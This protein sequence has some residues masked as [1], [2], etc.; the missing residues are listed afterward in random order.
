[1]ILRSV[2]ILCSVNGL[3][4]LSFTDHRSLQTVEDSTD[5][6][7]LRSVRIL[8]SVDGLKKFL[9]YRAQKS[10]DRRY[11]LQTVGFYGL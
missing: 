6:R 10:T 11:F 2:G 4:E 7:V 9:F 3:K 1:M 8:W 5:R